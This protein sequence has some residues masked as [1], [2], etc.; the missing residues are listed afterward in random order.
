MTRTNLSTLFTLLWMTLCL[1][2][3]GN[4][5]A[6][7]TF[8]VSGTVHD[9]ESAPLPGANVVLQADGFFKGMTTNGN[10]R[11]NI[12]GVPSGTY[13]F[14]VS[15]VGYSDCVKTITV[16]KNTTVE[17]IKM[18]EGELLD[19]VV[20]T[21]KAAEITVKGDTLVFNADSYKLS[22]GAT[23]EEL[24][25]R[26]PG[27]EI[28]SNGSITIN[29]ETV[30]KIMID[31]KEFFA[32]D[33]TVA[34]KNLPA[35][36]IS[37][38]EVLSQ[39]SDQARLT[40]F[41]DDDEQTVINL[42]T[43]LG[44][45]K[46]TFGSVFAGYGL[47]NRY[48]VNGIYNRFTD[49]SQWSLL[50][51]SNNTNNQGLEDIDTGG[52]NNNLGGQGDR[53]GGPG[54]GFSPNNMPSG[55]INTS[56]HIGFNGTWMPSSEWELNGNT[57]YGFTQNNLEAKSLTE[58]FLANGGSTFTHSQMSNLTRMHDGGVD[59]FFKWK[60]SD[61]TELNIRP[62]LH[63][64]FRSSVFNS[65]YSTLGENQESLNSGNTEGTSTSR[66]VASGLRS[67]FS[68]QL[69]DVGRT[70]SAMLDVN[71]RNTNGQSKT[72][73]N[74]MTVA[75]GLT[76]TQW[77]DQLTNSN[78]MEYR[79]RLNFVEP[80]TSNMLLQA[81][82]QLKQEF[83]NSLREVQL[84]QD[85]SQPTQS[86]EMTNRLTAVEGGIHLKWYGSKYDFTAGVNVS[87]TQ[88]NTSQL[89]LGNQTMLSK[90]HWFYS[91][92]LNFR[93]EPNKQTSLRL[94]YW[95]FAQTPNA[96]QMFSTPDFSNSLNTVIGNPNLSP[97]Y[98]HGLGVMFR[99]FI[100]KTQQSLS[101]NAHLYLR[102]NEVITSSTIDAT[103]GKSTTTYLNTPYTYGVR[104]FG[105]FSTPLISRAITLGLNTRNIYSAPKSVIN[106]QT[107]VIQSLVSNEML[108][109]SYTNDWLYLRTKANVGYQYA[110]NS[111]VQYGT[112][113]SWDW[114]VG[115][116]V[117]ISLPWNI[118]L[119]TDIT[120][121][122][123]AGYSSGYK[124]N[125]LNWDTS[126]SYS[127]WQNTATLRLKAYDILN[128]STNISRVVT[129]AA[130]IDTETNSLGR[131]IMLHF[132]YRFN[133]FAN[134]GSKSDMRQGPIPP[135]GG[136]H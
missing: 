51:S 14:K 114:G 11:F 8:S 60:P 28:G 109:L 122:T 117:T 15:F 34:T 77:Q 4:V 110:L 111:L 75:D 93:Y 127:F 126:I 20:V 64:N 106:G 52:N 119:D 86:I 42:T 129:S 103:T 46:G 6:Q 83:R 3:P 130:I 17:T 29:G 59:G 79:T 10:G 81:K 56:S 91:P 48:E 65:A 25:K 92:T 105:T 135:M 16:T 94:R 30:S 38:L 5:Q 22:A 62:M 58:T 120:Y 134:G 1:L 43:K 104:M 68:H 78:S 82:I 74:L 73:S 102:Q 36:L 118:K 128:R 24:I 23:L 99:T 57:R 70:F 84:T 63:L 50:A 7:S 39:K 61:R 131:S 44:S 88:M 33:P 31:G 108:S 26:L 76:N 115:G 45:K 112:T 55:G 72:L 35:E 71:Y 80:L 121:S 49:T 107:N 90:W 100:P 47:D 116:D 125:V 53:R 19:A 87:P 21:G 98:Q 18:D 124:S 85:G 2:L 12:T 69:N 95:S 133:I 40:G 54:G 41:D 13:T 32:G 96:S 67:V 89:L 123:N 132:I 97:I 113:R 37:K 101:L 136:F 66:L 27:A 9:S